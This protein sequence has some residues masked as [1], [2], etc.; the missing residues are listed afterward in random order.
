MLV[1]SRKLKEA[2]VIGGGDEVEGILKVIV[3]EI[4]QG[5]VTIPGIKRLLGGWPRH[6]K[7]CLGHPPQ[8]FAQPVASQPLRVGH[9]AT[10]V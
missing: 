3:L 2:V 7:R 4:K 9:A 5:R 8:H 10:Q 1:L 6:Q